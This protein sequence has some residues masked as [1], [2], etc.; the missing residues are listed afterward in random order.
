MEACCLEPPGCFMFI[1]STQSLLYK[2]VS[3]CG[4][5]STRTKTGLPRKRDVTKLVF[6]FLIGFDTFI[7]YFGQ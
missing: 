1:L 4:E 7:T 2:E 6:G 3:R 5:S